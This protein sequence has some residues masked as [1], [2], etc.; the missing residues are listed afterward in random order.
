M[1]LIGA[2]D[3]GSTF[4]GVLIDYKNDCFYTIN[5]GDSRAMTVYH[6]NH[7][8]IGKFLTTEHKLSNKDEEN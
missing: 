4:C 6:E 1:R 2:R 7:K 3:C 8:L 5:L